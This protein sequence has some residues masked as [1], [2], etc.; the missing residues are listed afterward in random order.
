[1]TNYSQSNKSEVLKEVV[2][3]IESIELAV[4]L[5]HYRY[6]KDLLISAYLSPGNGLTIS[7]CTHR[8]QIIKLSAF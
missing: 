5:S 8:K 4:A 6:W 3:L 2:I 7:L 1:M